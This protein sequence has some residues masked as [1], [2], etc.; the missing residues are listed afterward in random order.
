MLDIRESTGQSAADQ[1]NAE[2][3]Q[4]RAVFIPCNVTKN[5]EFDGEFFGF[6]YRSLQKFG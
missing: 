1:L 6:Y 4:K 5:S 3:G 2:F